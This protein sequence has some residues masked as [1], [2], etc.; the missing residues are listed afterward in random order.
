MARQHHAAPG[1]GKPKST[2]DP[3]LL[4]FRTADLAA[5]EAALAAC[6]GAVDAAAARAAV[7]SLGGLLQEEEYPGGGGGEG[8]AS[9]DGVAGD[10]R[11]RRGGRGRSALLRS[12]PAHPCIHFVFFYVFL[13][14]LLAG[15]AHHH[16]AVYRAESRRQAALASRLAA[17]NRGLLEPA[18][19]YA[20]CGVL[21]QAPTF[22]GDPCEP[23][24]DR[25]PV[26]AWL[27]VATTR[28]VAVALRAEAPGVWALP[29]PPPPKPPRVG[30]ARAPR[31]ARRRR[32]RRCRCCGRSR[33]GR[34][35]RAAAS[36]RPAWCDEWGGGGLMRCI[37]MVERKKGLVSVAV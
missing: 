17:L 5:L 1:W 14:I 23:Y 20:S 3:P 10:A 16:T 19:L 13:F 8:G 26:A 15:D 34:G 11:G 12:V 2:R 21:I 25:H 35:R 33:C 9:A 6:K 22:P 29:A 18:G 4:R 24:F 7:A 27:A 36:P 30:L 37:I 28:E 31:P 32:T